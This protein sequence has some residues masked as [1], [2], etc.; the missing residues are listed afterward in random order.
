MTFFDNVKRFFAHLFAK[1][2]TWEMIKEDEEIAR[3][4]IAQA[5]VVAN[6]VIPVVAPQAMPGVVA[7]E[8]AIAAGEKVADKVKAAVDAATA[9]PIA[10]VGQ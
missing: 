6:V 3:K 1:P 5:E 4:V 10:P 7:A 8:G 9:Q 2:V